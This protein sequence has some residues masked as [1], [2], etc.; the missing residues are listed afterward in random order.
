MENK[1]N[2]KAVGSWLGWAI[3]FLIIAIVSGIFGFGVISGVSLVIAKW[4]TV[5]FIVLFLCILFCAVIFVVLHNET[6][7]VIKTSDEKYDRE[8]LLRYKP[9]KSERKLKILILQIES[10]KN[11]IPEYGKISSEIKREIITLDSQ[12]KSIQDSEEIENLKNQLKEGAKEIAKQ[13]KITKE[14]VK[15]NYLD[16]VEDDVFKQIELK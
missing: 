6:K 7:N 14:R 5:I 3:V 10:Y 11:S 4:L 9:D 12:I 8:I 15:E 1:M 16:E 13:K 2:K